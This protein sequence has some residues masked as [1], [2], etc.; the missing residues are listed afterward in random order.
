MPDG[1]E[2]GDAADA[3]AVAAC[4][5]V[6][7]TEGAGALAGLMLMLMLGVGASAGAVLGALIGESAAGPVLMGAAA[8]VF[9][10]E[11]GFVMGF[12]TTGTAVTGFAAFGAVAGRPAGRRGKELG[13][14]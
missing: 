14:R 9:A 11:A 4:W 13:D 5:V 3:G 6:F 12:F 2:A 1:P 7:T 10:A 8:V